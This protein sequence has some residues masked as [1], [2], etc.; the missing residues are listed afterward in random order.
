MFAPAVARTLKDADS[1][2]IILET[3]TTLN[4]AENLGTIGNSKQKLLVIEKQD[5]F[6][7]NLLICRYSSLFKLRKNY[8]F[9]FPCFQV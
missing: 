7:R 8:R 3:N 6:G 9:V 4:V 5:V 1:V 2:T